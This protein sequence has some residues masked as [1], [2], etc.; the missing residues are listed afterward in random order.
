MW[1]TFLITP[2]TH[3]GI[4]ETRGIIGNFTLFTGLHIA[5][6]GCRAV[7]VGEETAAEAQSCE[8]HDGG[9]RERMQ[10]GEAAVF[11]KKLW[12]GEV[13]FGWGTGL[14]GGWDFVDGVGDFVDEIDINDISAKWESSWCVGGMKSAVDFPRYAERLL[15]A[16]E[17]EG[18]DVNSHFV[19]SP[20]HF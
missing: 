12:L 13:P 5:F 9:Q 18:R 7:V 2:L 6:F 19:P 16:S 3:R 8:R 15:A 10:L 4:F 17:S 1:Q 20:A 11:V 14:T